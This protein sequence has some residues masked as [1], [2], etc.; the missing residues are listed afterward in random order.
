MQVLYNWNRPPRSLH[1]FLPGVKHQFIFLIVDIGLTAGIHDRWLDN[2]YREKSRLIKNLF[3]KHTYAQKKSPCFAFYLQ[4]F[5]LHCNKKCLHKPAPD[6]MNTAWQNVSPTGHL[7]LT[8]PPGHIPLDIS[9]IPKCFYDMGGS[10]VE[11]L[12][13]GG[14][15]VWGTFWGVQGEMSGVRCPRTAWQPWVCSDLM[16]S[17]ACF[18]ALLQPKSN[19]W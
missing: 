12:A 16:S 19:G 4:S 7:P 17:G 18:P 14:G 6:K 11:R 3:T 9:P 15:D 2:M 1:D 8:S 10:G 5:D 13:Q